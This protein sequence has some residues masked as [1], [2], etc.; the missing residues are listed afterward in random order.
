MSG[1]SDLYN[2][3]A[4]F[5]FFIIHAPAV[6]GHRGSLFALLRTNEKN[7]ASIFPGIWMKQQSEQ[8]TDCRSRLVWHRICPAKKTV[9]KNV[10][11]TT[12]L[13]DSTAKTVETE[14]FFQGSRT[15]FWCISVAQL[16]VHLSLSEL[17][18]QP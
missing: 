18:L 10:F 12:F 3:I 15:L 5:F 2:Q 8:R 11:M 4:N 13:T 16:T 9:T 7:S 17:R 6:C 1:K 14:A